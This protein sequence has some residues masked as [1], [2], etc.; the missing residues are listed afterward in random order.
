LLLR[1]AMAVKAMKFASRPKAATTS[2][3]AMKA[4][5]AKTKS[6]MKTMKAKSMKAMKAKSMKA[7]KAS[8]STVAPITDKDPMAPPGPVIATVEPVACVWKQKFVKNPTGKYYQ[9]RF[10]GV[11]DRETERGPCS[12][13]ALFGPDCFHLL[14][15]S[16][17]PSGL[18]SGPLGDHAGSWTPIL[19]TM[20]VSGF[21]FGMSLSVHF[22]SNVSDEE[23]H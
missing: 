1:L 15:F 18:L 9:W 19:K 2:M 13:N 4:M 10:N 20:F 8:S 17:F 23:R 11:V 5:K 7:M 14:T 3:K 6:P 22:C 21:L 16:A 12:I